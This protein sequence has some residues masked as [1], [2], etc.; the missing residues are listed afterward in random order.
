VI[1]H[2]IPLDVEYYIKKQILPP[3][4]RIFE[5]FDV[6]VSS[7]DKY[8]QKGL[9]DFTESKSDTPKKHS[10]KTETPSKI[11]ANDDGADMGPSKSSAY[12]EEVAEDTFDST[13]S[14]LEETEKK[15]EGESANEFEKESVK[16][17]EDESANEFEKES[18]KESEDKFAN[19]F[20]KESVKESE[21]K[22]ENKADSSLTQENTKLTDKKK[23]QKSLFDF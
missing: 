3:V 19:E 10:H 14:F 4:E 23:P 13:I 22:S 20:E 15:S 7:L 1:K 9:F 17:S 6:D 16:E 12:K 2:N 11:P 5:V 18:A 8:R 21:K